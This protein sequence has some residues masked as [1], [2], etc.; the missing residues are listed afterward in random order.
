MWSQGANFEGLGGMKRTKQQQSG[1]SPIF[2]TR[3]IVCASENEARGEAARQQRLEDAAAVEWIY[4]KRDST[5]EWLAR[6]TPREAPRVPSGQDSW[7]WFPWGG[8]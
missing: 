3:D 8:C 4:L 6:R 2:E 5:G 7:W 1:D